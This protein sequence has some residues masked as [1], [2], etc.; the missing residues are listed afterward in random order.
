MYNSLKIIHLSRT[1]DGK[2]VSSSEIESN[3]MTRA[4]TN[5][6]KKHRPVDSFLDSGLQRTVPS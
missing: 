2:G 4:L 3:G 1:Q 5:S 6:T